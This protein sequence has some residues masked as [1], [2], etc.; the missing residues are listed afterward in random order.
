MQWIVSN[1]KRLVIGLLAAAAA[2]LLIMSVRE[3]RE[4]DPPGWVAMNEQVEN[5]LNMGLSAQPPVKESGQLQSTQ[6]AA[7]AELQVPAANAPNSGPAVTPSEGTAP[8]QADTTQQHTAA[9]GNDKGNTTVIDEAAGTT[10][11]NSN[12]NGNTNSNTESN[13]GG[14]DINHATAEQLMTLSGIGEA[15]ANAII[16][17]R[18]KNGPFRSVDDLQRVKGIGSK[19]LEKL[20]PSIVV[21]P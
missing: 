11:T 10:T 6:T 2:V 18:S 8:I 5:A 3:K 19:M 21:K 17:D 4:V 7:G 14:M 16:A 15:K 20:R 13:S 9:A 1:Q 12:T